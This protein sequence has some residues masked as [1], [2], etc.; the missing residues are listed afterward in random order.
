MDSR[1]P[2]IGI[3][4]VPPPI[5]RTFFVAGP[6]FVDTID[7]D[8]GEV[9]HAFETDLAEPDG[10]EAENRCFVWT[11]EEPYRAHHF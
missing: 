8:C 3:Q 4:Y 5:A 6:T 2:F 11:Y 10:R 1:F 7:K 9:V